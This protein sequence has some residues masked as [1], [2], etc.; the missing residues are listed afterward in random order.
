MNRLL[1]PFLALAIFLGVG[2]LARE[3]YWPWFQ[4]RL[5]DSQEQTRKEMEKMIKAQPKWADVKIDTSKLG[6][7]G[8]V[9]MP[10]VPRGTVG[11]SRPS[12]PRDNPIRQH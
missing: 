1:L 3:Y 5:K 9:S 2:Y 6:N 12:R 11:P 7:P 4:E 10:P 8:G